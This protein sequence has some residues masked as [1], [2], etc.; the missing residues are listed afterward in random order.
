MR[1]EGS[2][3]TWD[4]ERGFGFIEPAQGGQDIFVHIKAF[5][6]GGDRPVAGQRLRFEVEI[7]PQ[8][9]K[10]A[11]QVEWIKPARMP[12]TK[13]RESPA[14]WGT[15]TLFA[16]PAFVLIYGLIALIWGSPRL[17]PLVYLIASA[18]TFIAYAR[19][20]SAA[21]RGTRRTPE[22]TLHLLSMLGGWPGA[23]IAQQYVR[24]KS[25]KE[26]FRSVFWATVAI[27]V[28]GLVVICSPLGQSIWRQA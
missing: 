23:L 5:P 16:I 10:R 12:A 3:K 13:S 9:K 11:R 14:Q 22:N 21:R 28:V 6:S 1:I 24:H 25:T 27:N 8:G 19:D 7:G 15:A 18:I 17:M 20:K 26:A 4:D 2:L